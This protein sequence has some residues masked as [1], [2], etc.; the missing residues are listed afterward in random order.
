MLFQYKCRIVAGTDLA[1]GASLVSYRAGTLTYY[2]IAEHMRVGI[3]ENQ[4]DLGLTIDS[5]LKL[6]ERIST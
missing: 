5:L 3:P 1:L 4:P 6:Y 2:R